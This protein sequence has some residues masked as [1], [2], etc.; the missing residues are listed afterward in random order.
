MSPIS[1]PHTGSRRHE[2][3]TDATASAAAAEC[4]SEHAAMEQDGMAAR[5]TASVSESVVDDTD[6][7]DDDEDSD[8]VTVVTIS[9]PIHTPARSPAPSRRTPPTVS[10]STVVVPPM[11]AQD[12]A[13]L[14]VLRAQVCIC[15][16]SCECE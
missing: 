4:D 11:T 3:D 16:H 13:D 15:M 8:V 1:N 10:V 2:S 6:Q 12:E 14:R 7:Y 5:V 9:T